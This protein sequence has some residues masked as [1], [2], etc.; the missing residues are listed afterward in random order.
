[1]CVQ[2]AIVRFARIAEVEQTAGPL[3]AA[4]L[5]SA[6]FLLSRTTASCRSGEQKS[7]DDPTPTQ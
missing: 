7:N 6:P 5:V 2:E 1:M 3:R 4:T